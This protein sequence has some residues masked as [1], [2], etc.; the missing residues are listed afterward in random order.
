MKLKFDPVYCT[1][2]KYSEELRVTLFF[3]KPNNTLG[4]CKCEWYY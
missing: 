3:Y 2:L 4:L 1:Y